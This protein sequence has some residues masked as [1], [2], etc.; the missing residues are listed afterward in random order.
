MIRSLTLTA[1][2]VLLAL[3]AFTLQAAPAMSGEYVA[4]LGDCAACHTSEA[5]KPL[6]GGKGFSTPSAPSMPPTSPRQDPR[7]RQLQ[8]A[9]VHQGDARRITRSGDPSTRPCPTPPTPR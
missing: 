5:S 3:P 2:A 4:K 7:H 6:A 8:P 1:S 9:R